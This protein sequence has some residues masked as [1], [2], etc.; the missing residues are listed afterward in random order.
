MKRLYITGLILLIGV[1]ASAPITGLEHPPTQQTIYDFTMKN[2]DGED[3]S[4]AEFRGK[5]VLVVNVASKCGFTPQYEGL[6]DLYEEYQERGL[7][8]L[9]FPANNFGNQEPGSNDQIQEFCTLNY[10]VTFPMFAKISVKGADQHPLYSYLTSKELH[11]DFGGEITW[12]FNKF[13]IGPDGTV[14]NRFASKDEPKSEKVVQAIEA[15]L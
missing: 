15:A 9:G 10:G 11:P 7:V 14:L 3:V 13:L 1:L 2:I 4:L 6:Q 8:V 12:N 5:V